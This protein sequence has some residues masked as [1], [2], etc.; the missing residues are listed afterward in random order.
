[1]AVSWDLRRCSGSASPLEQG[2]AQHAE[3]Q[4]QCGVGW[5]DVSSQEK[6]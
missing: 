3:E 4:W 5:E 6:P 2:E 1:M